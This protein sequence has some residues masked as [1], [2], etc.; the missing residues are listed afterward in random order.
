MTEKFE[1]T[2]V[3]PAGLGEYFTEE[4]AQTIIGQEYQAKKPGGVITVTEAHAIENGN[5]IEITV[6]WT[7]GESDNG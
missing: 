5:A 4:S 6:E 7:E 3:V 1:F 2:F